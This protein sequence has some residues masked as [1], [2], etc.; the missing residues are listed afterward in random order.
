MDDR[1]YELPFQLRGDNLGS[2]SLT[3][4]TKRVTALRSTSKSVGI[5]SANTS[6]RVKLRCHPC[7]GK[8]MSPTFSQKPYRALPSVSVLDGLEAE[9]GCSPGGVL[10]TGFLCGEQRYTSFICESVCLREIRASVVYHI[11]CSVI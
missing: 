11:I 5:L 8:K 1:N 2:I 7:Q 4:T 9:V 10:R 6:R 3:E